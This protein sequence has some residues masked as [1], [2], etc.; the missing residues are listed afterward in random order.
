MDG[1]D[2]GVVQRGESRRFLAKALDMVGVVGKFSRQDLDR[3]GAAQLG[4]LSAVDHAH[5]AVADLALD[6]IRADLVR[7]RGHGGRILLAP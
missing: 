1:E 7:G 3:H 2:V 6:G 5:P 4:I